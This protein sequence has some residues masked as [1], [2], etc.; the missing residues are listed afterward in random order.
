MAI[1]LEMVTPLCSSTCTI[2]TLLLSIVKVE[3]GAKIIIVLSDISNNNSLVHVKLLVVHLGLA[4]CRNHLDKLYLSWPPFTTIQRN[5]WVF[6]RAWGHFK[7]LKVPGTYS[8]GSTMR[9]LTFKRWTSYL[10]PS[11]EML[12]L[13]CHLLRSLVYN[14]KP[15]SWLVW[16]SVMMRMPGQRPLLPISK[17]IWGWLFIHCPIWATFVVAIRI[18]TFWSEFIGPHLWMKLNG[19]GASTLKGAN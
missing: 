7:H 3:P 12:F 2:Q 9:P 14:L 18:P 4:T 15:S 19:I 1:S 5:L 10:Q 6:C 16:T 13:N 11:T 8:R 17:M